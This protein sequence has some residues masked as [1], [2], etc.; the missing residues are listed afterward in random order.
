MLKAARLLKHDSTWT[1]V[2]AVVTDIPEDIADYTAST[3]A[4]YAMDLET[5]AKEQFKVTRITCVG[6]ASSER[7]ETLVV[8]TDNLMRDEALLAE[9]QNSNYDVL[10]LADEVNHFPRAL[11][12]GPGDGFGH[13]G[14]P[15]QLAAEQ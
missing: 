14:V 15:D 3:T 2:D 11:L 6:I 7:A 9:I 1:D 5:N 8:D 10:E 12:S 13:G 4:T